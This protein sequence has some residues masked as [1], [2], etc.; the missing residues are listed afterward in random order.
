MSDPGPVVLTGSPAQIGI[1]L[2]SAAGYAR[3]EKSEATRRAYASDFT[4]FRVWCDCRSANV[5]L[6][7]IETAA[8][9][10]AHLADAGLTVS[11]ICRR[12]VAIGYAY[13][14]AG[15]ESFV[16]SESVKAILH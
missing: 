13:W 15:R 2:E 10:L 9:Y 11:T 16:G 8:A 1:S 6:V 4:H 12:V 5:L 7:V 3:S 14:L